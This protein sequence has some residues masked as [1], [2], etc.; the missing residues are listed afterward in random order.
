MIQSHRNPSPSNRNGICTMP[1]P[2]EPDRRHSFRIED[3]ARVE[4]VPLTPAQE[5]L[6]LDQILQ[7]SQ[8]FELLVELQQLDQQLQQQLFKLSETNSV[9]ASALG[10]INRKIEQLALHLGRRS[11][12]GSQP[13][14]ITLSEGGLSLSY[15]EALPLDSRCALRLLLLPGG[16]V[17]QSLARVVY[18]HPDS[19]QSYRIGLSFIELPDSQRDLIARHILAHQAQL[20]RQL[21]QQLELDNPPN[22]N[23]PDTP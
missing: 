9:L 15:S 12:T 5:A 10:L 13:S 16:Y 2:N 14:P 17:L 6:P 19:D 20:R 7:P 18:S 11:D 22:A 3:R 23:R 21:R 4:F 1:L 8:E